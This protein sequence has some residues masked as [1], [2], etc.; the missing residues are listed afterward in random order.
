MG[1]SY[2]QVSNVQ[3]G[4]YFWDTDPGYGAGTAITGITPAVS[5]SHSF[6]APLS[7]LSPGMHTLFFRFR[8]ATGAWGVTHRSPVLILNLPATVPNISQGE[9]FW[10]TDPGYGAGTPIASFSG[11]S[12]VASSIAV[13]LSGLTPGLHVL[14]V[15]SR[16]NPGNW[17]QTHGFPVFVLPSPALPNVSRLEYFW[18]TDPGYGNGTLVPGFTPGTTPQTIAALVLS[19]LSP[20]IHTLV[21]RGKDANGKWSQSYA[22]NVVISNL[23][24]TALHVNALEYFWNT[25][26]GMGNGTPVT[27][28]A[29]A[30][31][32]TP[33]IAI[34][35]ASLPIGVNTLFFRGR[36]A[37]GQWGITHRFPV[38]VASVNSP[39]TVNAYEYFWDTDPGYGAGTSVTS[40]SPAGAVNQSFAIS[41]NSL[42]PG[43]HTLFLRSK[44]PGGLYGQTHAFPVLVQPNPTLPQVTRIEYF[45]DT[46]PGF[47]AATLMPG[48]TAGLTPSV[49]ASA[50]NISSLSTGIHTLNVRSRDANGRWS[51]TY[52][53][54]VIVTSF[55]A[56]P[57]QITAIE[58]FWDID[59][60]MGNG[61]ALTG[62]S[63]GTTV[64]ALSALPLNSLTTGMHTLFY[65]ARNA[66]GHWGI[67][68]RF[69]VFIASIPALSPVSSFEYFW[70]ADPGF[71]LATQV[72]GFSAA[73]SVNHTFAIPLTGLSTGIQT[74]FI[75]PRNAAGT[76]GQTYAFPVYLTPTLN[77]AQLSKMEYWWDTDPG[78][79]AATPVP[80]FSPGVTSS[81]TAALP[82]SSLN[83]GIHTL[84]VRGQDQNGRWGV[85]HTYSV[86]VSN[87]NLPLS[88]ITQVEYFWDIDPGFGAGTAMTGFS[89][90]ASIQAVA[91]LPLNILAPGTHVLFTRARNANGS[92][93][94]THRFSV[95]VSS[96]PPPPTPGLAQIEYFWDTDPGFGNGISV[97]VAP[98]QEI[99]TNLVV[100]LTGLTPGIHV[101]GMRAQDTNGVWGTTHPHAVY[102]LPDL[103]VTNVS[104]IE[105]F[106]DTDPGYGSATALPGLITAPTASVTHAISLSGMTQGIH[107]L[108][109]RGRSSSGRW[110]VAHTYGVVVLPPSSVP[111]NVIAA[112]YF[113]DT[114]PGFGLATAVSGISAGPSISPV[115]SLPLG[116]LT[117]GMHTLF[118][119]GRDAN[120]GWSVTHRFPVFV[121]NVSV[122]SPISQFE[123]FW[124]TDPGY[125]LGTV[126][127]GFPPANQVGQN[128]VIP[129]GSLSPGVHV[130]HLRAADQN[131]L[132]GQTYAFPVFIT[133][134]LTLANVAQ[135]EY[136]WDTDPGVGAGLPITS[137]SPSDQVTSTSALPLSGLNAGIHTLAVRAKDDLGR[138]GVAH[139]YSVFVVNLSPTL[140]QISQIEYFWDTDPGYGAGTAITGFP[141]GNSIQAVASISPS[142]LVP[143]PHV[144]FVRAKD[145]NGGWST[146]HR[147][148]IFIASPPP[149]PVPGLAQLEYFWDT[150]PGFGNG[151]G[152]A[153]SPSQ[154]TNTNVVVSTTGLTPGVHVLGMRAQ[155]T[156]GVWG[157]TH[158]NPVYMLP[159]LQVTD[160]TRMEY[161]WNTDPGY[162]NAT[163]L[164][165]LTPSSE[166]SVSQ[167][168]SMSGLNQGINYLTVRSRNS[169]GKWSVAHTYGVLLTSFPLTAP[170][171]TDVE[172][173]WNTDPGFGQGTP[174]VGFA[175]GTQITHAFSIPLNSL[176]GGINTLF[177]RGRNALGEWSTTHRF[178]VLIAAPQILAPVSKF[179]YFWDTDPGFGNGTP[180]SGFS[181]GLI[182][183]ESFA[184]ALG[185]LSPGVHV[186]GFRSAD[187]LNKWGITHTFPV[188]ITPSL[189]LDQVSQVEYFWDTDPGYGAGISLAGFSP[190]TSVSSSQAISLSGLTQG[191]H[192]LVV[193][194]KSST[195]KWSVAHQ[196]S[197][198]ITSLP[199]SPYTVDAL[200]YFW[201]TDPGMGN[202]TAVTGFVAG[203]QVSHVF[204][205]PTTSL[206]QGMNTLFV[207]GRNSN[208]EWGIVHRYPVFLT[209]IQNAAPIAELEYFWDTD[210]GMGNATSVSG[211]TLAGSV[212]QN[213]VVPVGS[214]T[215]GV[216]TLGVRAADSTQRWGITHT[217]PVYVTPSLTLENVAAIEYFWDSDPGY[218]N[219][220]SLGGVTPATTVSSTQAL[221]LA[222]LNPGIHSLMVRTKSASG[223]WSVA[224]QWS[225]L[226]I[227]TPP[228][229]HQVT[230]IEYFWNTDPGFGN[231]VVV[232]GLTPS[233][234]VSQVLP[235]PM[236]GLTN[237]MNSLFIRAQNANGEWGITHRFPV[238]VVSLAQAIPVAAF[239]YFWDTDPGYGSGTSVSSFSPAG[240][241]NQN[242]A[243][244]LVGVNSGLRT[245]YIRGKDSLNVWGQTYAFPVYV[246][247]TLTLDQVSQL[248][249]F[250]DTDPGYGNAT[251]LTGFSPSTQ[252]TASSAIS[253][254]NLQP[255]LRTLTIRA[256]SANG[257]WSVA[258]SFQALISNVAPTLSPITA[259]EYFWDTD[260]GIGNA[261]PITGFVSSDTVNA[262]VAVPVGAL[263][264]GAHVLF[265]RARNAQGHWGITHRW[266]V[267][268]TIPPVPLPAA[269]S[270]FEY[271]WNT[272]PGLG[273]ATSVSGF[274]SGIDVSH[275]FAVPLSGLNPGL[276][277]L[278]LR[279]IDT[280]G[281]VG[282]SYPMP[283]FIVPSQSLTNLSRVEYFWDTDPGFG[284]ATA[285]TGFVPASEIS[286]NHGIS[287]SSVTP[288]IHTLTVRGKDQLG[289]WSVSHTYSVIISNNLNPA[290]DVTAIEYF[291][292]TDPGM[293]NGTAVPVTSPG[294]QVAQVFNI[295]LSTLN[296]GTNTLFIRS[297]NQQGA[298]SITHRFPVY[299]TAPITLAPV[300]RLEYFWDTDPG[301]G[302]GVA[303]TGFS[304]GQSISQNVAISLAAVNPGLR[305]LH[306]RAQDTTGKWG[307]T[308]PY[309]IYVTPNL[310]LSDVQRVEYF[311]DTDPGYG[312]GTALSGITPSSEV[313]SSQALS[314]SA[315][316]PGIHTLTVRAKSNL[317]RWSVAHTYAVIVSNM[318]A[319]L[320]NIAAIEYF[321]NTDPGMGN[322]TAVTSFSPGAQVSHN[323]VIPV[324][325]L[326]TGLNTLFI[327][328]KTTSGQWSITHR[329]PVFVGGLTT[330]APISAFE[331]FWNTD[332]GYGNGSPVSGFALSNDV[333]HS[334]LV[335][336]SG[337]NAGLNTL[338]LRPIDSTLRYGQT[339]AFPVYMV[340]NPTLPNLTRLEYYWDT[341]PGFGNATAI[342]GYTPGNEV[343]AA[344]ALPLSALN[345]GLH[346]LAV[347]GRDAQGRWSVTHTYG[348]IIS[349]FNVPAPNITA[350]E[351]FW[352]TDP[353]IGNGTSVTSF[354]P[355]DTVNTQ[356]AIPLTVAAGPHVLFLRARNALGHWS[357][358]HR[359][360]VNVTLPPI[361]PPAPIARFEY[362]WDTDPG[363]GNATSV[364]GFANGEQVNHSFAVPMTGL[365]PGLHT[366]VLRAI[367]STSKVGHSYPM[368]VFIVPPSTLANI[369][370]LEYFWDND[371]GF[372]N[373]S[374]VVGFVPGD[375]VTAIQAIP[376][377]NL[378]PGFHTLT[379]RSRTTDGRW[380]VAHSYTVFVTP[381][382]N[383]SNI[384]RVEYF[385]NTDPGMGNGVS[386]PGVV[387]GALVNQVFTINLTG[388]SQGVN[389]LFVR[390]M[391]AKGDYSITHRYP[392][393]V[394]TSGNAPI[395]RF[396]Y[397]WDTDPGFGVG[398]QVTSF[399]PAADVNQNI[400]I[401]LT[402]LN[403]GLRT[404]FVRSADT[405]GRWGGTYAYPVYL[406]P[407][408]ALPQVSRLEYFWNTDPGFGSA[409]AI[410]GLAA[411]SDVTGTT[412]ISLAGLNIGV[413]YLNVRAKDAMGRWSVTHNYNVVVIPIGNGGDVTALEYF[414]DTDPG[415]GSANAVTNFSPSAS[416]THSF[417]VSMTGLSQGLHLLYV[418]GK[419]QAGDWGITHRFP[420]FVADPNQGG[421]AP[422]TRYEYFW[423]TDPGMGAATQVTG[424]AT[425]ASTNHSFNISL[426]GI[427]PGLRTLH[428][429]PADSLGRWGI[430]HAYPVYVMPDPALPNVTRMEY[431]WDTDPGV[432]S[433]TAISITPGQT[434]T[435]SLA[436]PLSSLATGLHTL[437][438]RSRDANGRWSVT[439]TWSV[440]ITNQ[441]ASPQPITAVEY[442]WNTDPG[443]GNA[444]ALTSFAPATSVSPSFAV[445]VGNLPS[446]L[447]TLYI[448]AKNQS[449]A[450]GI[451]H[452]FPVFVQS[453]SAIASA[454]IQRFEYFIDTD[455]GFGA[456]TQVTGFSPAAQVNQN[457]LIPLTGLA[458]GVRNIGIRAMDT[459][460]RWGQTYQYPVYLLNTATSQVAAIEY[461]WDTDP[462]FG[463]GTAIPVSSS[464]EV[465]ATQALPLSGLNTGI[466]NLS[467]RSKSNTGRWSVS[468]HFPVF[469]VDQTLLPDTITQVEYFFDVDPGMGQGNAIAGVTPGIQV[470]GVFPI[471]LTSLAQGL[472]QIFIRAKN[473]NG[474]WG[475]T[476]R[477]P[478]YILNQQV[479]PEVVAA[480]FF[481]NTDPG[482]GAA[483]PVPA[484][485]SATNVNLNL[486]IPLT[487]LNQGIHRV[488]VRT[489]DNSG[490]WGHSFSEIF[491]LL[492]IPSTPV[493]LVK[494]EYFWDTDPG[495]NSGTT[496][497]GVTSAVLN[498]LSFTIPAPP[499]SPG[500]HTLYTRYQDS[501]GRWGHTHAEMMIVY[502]GPDTVRNLVGLEYFI[503]T[504][505]GLGQGTF[506]PFNTPSP[507]VTE[508]VN[509]PICG[510]ATG[511]YTLY[512][513]V[514][515]Q[516]GR[517][518]QTYAHALSVTN[519]GGGLPISLSQNGPI[520]SGDTLSLLVTHATFSSPAVTYTWSG[521]NNFNQTVSNPTLLN[522]QP[523]ASGMYTVTVNNPLINCTGVDS[524]MVLVSAG[525]PAPVV[526]SPDT[527][528]NGANVLLT[529]FNSNTS[530]YYWWDSPN[531]GNI[532]DS[533]S[534]F[535]SQSF[536]NNTFL[537]EQ[538]LFYV[539]AIDTVGCG[540]GARTT[541][542]V[543]VRPLP[544]G[545]LNQNLVYQTNSTT[546]PVNANN[547][548]I[549]SPDQWVQ[550]VDANNAIIA[551]VKEPAGS[552]NLGATQATATLVETNS[553]V[554]NSKPFLPKVYTITPAS[555]PGPNDT[556]IVR[557]F[558][559]Q[560]DFD[561]LNFMAG[562]GF[563]MNELQVRKY[564]AN[565]VGSQVL[566]PAASG[567]SPIIID[568]SKITVL[569]PTITGLPNVYALEFPLTSF[570]TFFMEFNNNPTPL[571]VTLT[572]WKADCDP[573]G[574][575]LQWT[576]QAELN[577]QAFFIDRSIDG[578]E[579]TRIATI[580]GAGTTNNMKH[581]SHVDGFSYAG[582]VYYRLT[583][584]DFDGATEVFYPVSA[585]CEGQEAGIW[586]NA[587]PNPTFAKSTVSHGFG[588]AGVQWELM[589]VSGRAFQRG[590]DYNEGFTIDLQSAA[591]GTYVLRL[592]GVLAQETI[593]LRIIKAQ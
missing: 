320:E 573:K 206:S 302:N 528:C 64:S 415:K 254:A 42:T 322:A 496:I 285:L 384:T 28:F 340:P 445:P 519:N 244:S 129:V 135:L 221:S 478:V 521:P 349:N 588:K 537:Y 448:R 207:R 335:P 184:I 18:D 354:T 464:A 545:V 552:S 81:V 128:F 159:A 287:L 288:G 75:R 282:H 187:T 216:H 439:H 249:Y 471:P 497:P 38:F 572:E 115:L 398:T 58:S 95:F 361:P 259:I 307:Q 527:V 396:E 488:F 375:T 148:S 377:Q 30:A 290:P 229:P 186:L 45:W 94:T 495:F 72:T 356:V 228:T 138:W 215:P 300:Q 392:V 477:F 310:A 79:G 408:A 71:G 524:I 3:A 440:I 170:N 241:V 544:G 167:A 279:A 368:P 69:P 584:Q 462:G 160:V 198:L 246:T 490:V 443:M 292:N 149:P 411:S 369:N 247:P 563:T 446:G 449:G 460:G 507:L 515:D 175:Q 472:H 118:V 306:F 238:Y 107:Y 48:F 516:D 98:N 209:S 185:A 162:G 106:W 326:N 164:G 276:N 252:I 126:I 76:Q 328:S 110:S 364:T 172:Y 532:I 525:A 387:A 360:A 251:S 576:T 2:A 157:I 253:I 513:R 348:V 109:V 143:G 24:P 163:A 476:Q 562:G 200:E 168:I 382:A 264:A 370:R 508:V 212:N 222:S 421:G 83:P 312:N 324:S 57:S 413:N 400:A 549:V 193:R 36:N 124:D 403:A 447:Q 268:I 12:A 255:G 388:L 341:D 116:S 373:G 260:P 205:I 136:F 444:T 567:F 520:C 581:Y 248:E 575:R 101:L 97:P 345:P 91:A 202:A 155:D 502:P 14:Y 428:V 564:S 480:E 132:T 425:G 10:D 531:G 122:L 323:M 506:V 486:A 311:W 289:R 577:N 19:S 547:C 87:V 62:F 9:Y 334:F 33:T 220:T 67:T 195:G 579:W 127:S 296:Q 99:N 227:N 487:N 593:S 536:V 314:L 352:D 522:A 332:P 176:N 383:P 362:F 223:K 468:H 530:Q 553:A 351:Y 344:A 93:S 152:V 337:V 17:G 21:V 339:Y 308:Y 363:L 146:T 357:I 40:F 452:R 470:N 262:Q 378:T 299:I 139:T 20:G 158:P 592:T 273:N 112:E 171:I 298:W 406:M 510:L 100:S 568:T 414:W 569:T 213:I 590:I 346:T 479:S 466:H 43:L 232:S 82:L 455:P 342:T 538:K 465:S 374:A 1:V 239:E 587:S 309:P 407:S 275:S 150:D 338:H 504:D 51:Q 318:P 234:N 84:G 169:Q 591:P 458:A 327:R 559:T 395:S 236:T 554:F 271:F 473:R 188:Y 34:P 173:F 291:W 25:D 426:A 22:Y 393:F 441:D 539:S 451:T 442:F 39:L 380:G 402:N 330:A 123:Y 454:P 140:P 208:G 317:G 245:L 89:A 371:P 518:G 542:S 316:T 469:V 119:R 529:A 263:P 237:G 219:A 418:R 551:S 376:M 570:S 196:Y 526:L 459:L 231:G 11:S 277:T 192:S 68:Q 66:N 256:K 211:F 571:P 386:V 286:V 297:K 385:W 389:T 397:F 365:T 181:P 343:T 161:F 546:L 189:T 177:V 16:S 315:L 166:V 463:A 372:G 431:F 423:D 224:H 47:G 503:D 450:W 114:D 201:N 147:F 199:S 336:L 284:N 257:Q 548:V 429:R 585:N 85:V 265:I 543:F 412:A 61:T 405:L 243:V 474:H 26:P 5:L 505:P 534:T 180:V 434:T 509:L 350:I 517:Y 358:T 190:N 56:S 23:P 491:T 86:V 483:T 88:D 113:W 367:D 183:N 589:D 329:F 560:E 582:W 586:A 44:G 151:T 366:L 242:L 153:L 540:G 574:V 154:Q 60:G 475:I 41:L 424:F 197:V 453:T 226:I 137:F 583:Q 535:L 105:Y 111:A 74:L 49:A 404:L 269:I 15:R 125:G 6:S 165:G 96:P 35:L 512:V 46:D 65:R 492:N 179:E 63:P 134:T 281:K 233:V 419:N 494:G 381:D 555:Q 566:N 250:W 70:N 333:N 435:G 240:S 235:I 427:T 541:N 52:T 484:F 92:W 261:S 80:G 482:F 280:T 133:P 416:L 29:S 278:V 73:N 7:S 37:N 53:Y 305:V 225:V 438:V 514:K 117:P 50:L 501:L 204:N 461:F 78:Y 13:P 141:S 283:I 304:A 379:V 102:V 270:S 104:R 578:E 561:S 456:A 394:G 178:P 399:S 121:Q 103:S 511:N 303:V 174:V 131:L 499:N 401:P 436:I 457:I 272:D 156:N 359:F 27:S 266:S 31:S 353:G 130:L 142:A 8:N 108:T 410:G 467:V 432:G 481:I 182:A 409:T 433:A 267:S 120:G 145:A 55:S 422:V 144:F 90:G 295:P 230:S 489:Q 437:S 485:A 556:V 313:S 54:P 523:T 218:G 500:V 203:T 420:V 558:Y 194:S 430:T 493:P 355:S 59:P 325:G 321:W 580:P 214:L 533:G 391:N 417:P 191:I 210:P 565:L 390:G 32:V 498:N 217:F 331:Y 301:Y 347:R 557:L 4:E 77:A 550:F 274:T 294:I 258:H 293:G 319:Q